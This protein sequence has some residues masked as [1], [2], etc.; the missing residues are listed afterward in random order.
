MGRSMTPMGVAVSVLFRRQKDSEGRDMVLGWGAG[1]EMRGY[2]RIEAPDGGEDT[3]II[4]VDQRHIHTF[5]QLPLTRASLTSK[6]STANQV[7]S[8]QSTLRNSSKAF[9]KNPITSSKAHKTPI[10]KMYIPLTNPLHKRTTTTPSPAAPQ[11]DGT[12]TPTGPSSITSPSNGFIAQSPSSSTASSD[13]STQTS[14]IIA[15]VVLVTVILLAGA[16]FWYMKRNPQ[17]W[18]REPAVRKNSV[19]SLSTVDS[20]EVGERRDGNG[21]SD[22]DVEKEGRV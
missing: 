5:V 13:A 20:L 11:T 18:R 15:V 21:I 22:R 19:G 17:K 12:S 3:K 14:I 4:D 7:H 10:I 8:T 16:V 2:K 9:E 6:S 1:W